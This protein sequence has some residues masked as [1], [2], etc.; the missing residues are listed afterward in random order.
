MCSHGTWQIVLYKYFF[1][2]QLQLQNEY[3]PHWSHPQHWHSSQTHWKKCFKTK[4]VKNSLNSFR[5]LSQLNFILF[6]QFNS[7]DLCLDYIN[8]FC[9]VKVALETSNMIS[10]SHHTLHGAGYTVRHF[11]GITTW[12]CNYVIQCNYC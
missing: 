7:I 12:Y 8:D 11:K 3:V 10:T 6:N 2:Y 1:F 5:M 9:C 4:Q